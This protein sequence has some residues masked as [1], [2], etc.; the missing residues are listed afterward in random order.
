MSAVIAIVITVTLMLLANALYVAAEF[1]TVGSRK[2]RIA[3]MADSGNWLA[4]QLFPIMKDVKQLDNYIAACQIGITASSLVLGA[5]GQDTIARL[6]APLL[7][8]TGFVAEAVA[9]SISATGVLILL[10]IMQVVLGELLPKS[11]AVQ[12]PEKIALAVVVPIKWSLVIFR[13]FIWLFNGSSNLILSLFKLDHGEGHTNTHSP[14]EIELLVSDSHKGGLIDAKEQ[15]MLRNAFRMRE[16]AARQVMVPRTRMVAA[17]VNS[18]ITEVLHIAIEAGFSR[19]PV[20]EE[21]IDNVIG[22]VHIKELFRQYLHE[23]DNLR[24]C[25]REVMYVPETMPIMDVWETLNEKRQ[26]IVIVFDEY[27]GT[28][29]LITFEDLIEEIFGELRDEYDSHEMA[30]I[31]WDQQGRTHLRGDLLIGDINE[32]LNLNLPDAD[33]DT[34]GGLVFHRLGRPP[35]VGDEVKIDHLVVRVEAVADLGIS[36]ISF[37]LS[38][39]DQ[40]N[41]HE[42]EEGLS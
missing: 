27:G 26:Y 9:F 25:L 31:S 37:Q 1:A 18:G 16:L 8:S 14:G 22:F 15:Q 5:Y 30:L 20:Y 2:T 23:E 38:T 39:N 6:L 40:V 11:I 17:A 3:Q 21:T 41:I 42:W 29:G 32:Y 34:L 4:G 24:G 12:Y 7:A 35:K 28:E 10:T 13:V 36:E 19:I 33:A